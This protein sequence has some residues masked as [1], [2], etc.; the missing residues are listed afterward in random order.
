MNTKILSICTL[1]VILGFGGVMMVKNRNNK[2]ND[3]SKLIAST[4]INKNQIAPGDVVVKVTPEGFVPTEVTIK[5]G[6]KVVW[7]NESGTYTWPA[8]DLHPTHGVYP[9][10]DP[11]EPIP[12]GQAWAFVFGKAGQWKFHDH[13]KPN[14]RG[15]VNVE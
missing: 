3:E 4:F 7:L 11:L 9:E 2:Q 13:L 14:R 12:A 10:F 1:I 6:D 8:S 5:K 15:G